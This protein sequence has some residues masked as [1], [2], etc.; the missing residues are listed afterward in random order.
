M[1]PV[2]PLMALISMCLRAAPLV[3][4][5]E[6]PG[7]PSGAPFKVEPLTL[8]VEDE[9]GSVEE[10]A[11]GAGI[12]ARGNDIE[13]DAEAEEC[14]RADEEKPPPTAGPGRLSLRTRP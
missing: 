5:E 7:E 13:A 8:G 1:A 11:W 2:I 9:E 6:V 3:D 14:I 4:L 12:E 10:R